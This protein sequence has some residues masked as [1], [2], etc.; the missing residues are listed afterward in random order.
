MSTS[1]NSLIIVALVCGAAV[2]LY[3]R[4]RV[5]ASVTLTDFFVVMLSAQGMYTGVLLCVGVLDGSKN[6][7]DFANERLTLVVGGIAVVW[8]S[9][10]SIWDL[11]KR[12]RV[13][14]AAARGVVV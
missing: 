5:R 2:A 9:A 12:K 13:E 14:A 10:T 8:I 4:L 7:G 11:V 3:V 6:L 1:Q